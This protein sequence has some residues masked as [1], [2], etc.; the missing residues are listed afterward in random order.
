M[1]QIHYFYC[2]RLLHDGWTQDEK[3]RLLAWF[4][5]TK[6]WTGGHSFTPFLENILRDLNPVFTAADRSRVVALGD[7]LPY[8]A[9]GLIYLAPPDQRPSLPALAD[10]Y[11]RALKMPA[12][13]KANE[14]KQA[15][16]L[17][18]AASAAP[19]AQAALRRIWDM[20]PSQRDAV[21][22]TLARTPSPGNWPY[23]ISALQSAPAS[24][25]GPIV[26]GLMKCSVKPKPDDPAPYRTL[27]LAST[28]LPAR[29][30]WKA[31]EL[32]R[33]WTN[34]RRFGADQGDW[35]PELSAWAKWFVQTFPKEPAL[36]D[37][38]SDKPPESK[39][40]YAELLAFLE[41]D[42][43]ARKGNPAHG[44]I[45]FEKAQCLKC[46]KYGKD[47]EGVG[48]DLTA[49]SKRFKRADILESIIYPSKVISDQYR[50]TFIVTR[51]GQQFNGLAAPQGDS[52][53]VLQGDGSKV[54]LK[55]DEI[56]QQFA[57]LV[58]VMPER[59]LDPLTKEEIA[60]LFAFLESEAKP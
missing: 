30:R 38:A 60:D 41:K 57:S 46:H 36:P 18:I 48:P 39:Y 32:L 14:L 15:I 44:R 23:L 34:G 54:T 13:P 9:L 7:H 5:S 43:A 22:G 2:L 45:V 37:V 58:S 47:G 26:D 8:A 24:V 25:L 51:K 42:P 1:Q 35:K 12:W 40:K 53:T 27:L 29:E 50:S 6:T 17:S 52:I 10:F 20:D 4:D 21:A 33:H 3:D 56:E 16:I 55:K 19:E 28:R 31:V 11:V 59:L 49:V